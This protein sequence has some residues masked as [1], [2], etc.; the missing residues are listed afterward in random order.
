M[1][2]QE[3][4]QEIDLKEIFYLLLSNIKTI[5][6]LCVLGVLLLFCYAKFWLP[7][8]YT[9]S[10]SIF[11]KNS[12][13]STNQSASSSDLTAARSLATT[14]MVILDDDVVY[15]KVSEQLLYIYHADQMKH[16]FTIKT[17][18]NGEEYIPASEIRRLVKTTALNNTEVIQL[19]AVTEDPQLSAEICNIIASYAKELLIQVTKAGSVET[20]GT[21]KVPT[22]PSGPNT[23][24]Y[25][26][27]GGLLGGVLAVAII[28]IRKLLDNCVGTAEDIKRRF[29]IPVL[30]EIPDLTMEEKEGSRYGY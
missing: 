17:D 20:I 12:A 9:S 23:K 28:V 8:K 7:V 4:E 14:Y 30:G 16:F 3:Q 18:E 29:N 15:D 19:T 22:A 5:I 26:L 6:L 2:K 11:V 25:A 21:A 10:V 1:E 27:I 24:R 13:D